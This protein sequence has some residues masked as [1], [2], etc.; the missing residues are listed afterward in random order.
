MSNKIKSSQISMTTVILL[1]HTFSGEAHK[2]CNRSTQLL[3]K[4]ELYALRK[5]FLIK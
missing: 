2:I 4:L 1:A 5:H 3:M